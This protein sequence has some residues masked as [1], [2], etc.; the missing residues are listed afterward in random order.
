MRHKLS[1]LIL[2][3]TKELLVTCVIKYVKKNRVAI[4]EISASNIL[5]EEK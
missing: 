5:D 4:I 3:Y 2:Q 1:G